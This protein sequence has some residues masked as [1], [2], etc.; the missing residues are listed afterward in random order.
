MSNAIPRNAQTLVDPTIVANVHQANR[1]N[2]VWAERTIR[3][4]E[5]ALATVH[6]EMGA[7][8]NIENVTSISGSNGEKIQKIVELHSNLTAAHDVHRELSS[9]QH[10]RARVEHLSSEQMAILEGL[11]AEET[12]HTPRNLEDAVLRAMGGHYRP[13]VFD[14]GR[15]LEVDVGSILGADFITT[16]GVPPEV[17]RQSQVAYALQATPRVLDFLNA[18]PTDQHSIKFLTETISTRAAAER[19]EAGQAAEA[20]ISY[21]ETTLA[22]RSVAARLP[23]SEEQL[24]DEPM[25]RNLLRNRLAYLAVRRVDEQIAGGNGSAPNIAGIKNQT[26]H[27]SL[28]HGRVDG[29]TDRG[30]KDPAE[31]IRKAMTIVRFQ[32]ESE[33]GLAIIDPAVWELIQLTK[34][35]GA[36]FLFGRPQDTLV[37]RIWGMPVAESTHISDNITAWAANE[38]WGA[39]L[40]PSPRFIQVAYRRRAQVEFGRDD[41]DFSKF[42]YTARVNIRCQLACY[43]PASICMIGSG[44]D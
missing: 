40:D 10:S 36:G 24:E 14:G 18:Y 23:V 41:D 27:Q 11:E 34:T 9:L 28:K 38:E 35:T 26:G 16:D 42:M 33:P 19:A 25:V 6:E 31:D 37:D 20:D 22:I 43:R 32:G 8:N 39:V 4:C 5:T 29:N 2:R 13:E 17:R 1:G 12:A 7:D 44:G 15:A 30:P 3:E 21:A